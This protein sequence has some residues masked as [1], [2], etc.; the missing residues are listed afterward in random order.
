MPDET[1]QL[2]CQRCQRLGKNCF[3]AEVKT[4]TRKNAASNV[5][6]V[7]ELERK[8]DKLSSLLQEVPDNVEDPPPTPSASGPFSVGT[9]SNL[10]GGIDQLGMQI[11]PPDSSLG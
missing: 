11:T 9:R 3:Y 6:R 8:I 2:K 7:Q 4:R 5:R 1:S 10:E